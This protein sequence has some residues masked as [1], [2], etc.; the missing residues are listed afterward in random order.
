MPTH[1]SHR[2]AGY[3]ALIERLSLGVPTPWHRSLVAASNTQRVDVTAAGVTEIYPSRYWPGDELC[4]HLEFALKYDGTDL[5][6]LAQVLPAIGPDALV[7]WI[8]RAPQG[9]YARRAWHLFEMLTRQLL[10]IPDLTRGNYIDL[11]DADAYYVSNAP[12][13]VRRQR[14]NDNLL[15][16]ADFC[17]MVRRTA[18]IESFI[19]KDFAARSRNLMAAY[20]PALLR[21]ALSYLYTKET[22]SSFEIE[23]I[24]PDPTRTER[25][26]ALLRSAATEDLCAK[27]SL[28]A[29]QNQIVDARF[30]EGDYRTDQNY[31][32]ETV[33]YGR[34]RIHYVCP[35]PEH[36]SP[37][38]SGLVESHARMA[39]SGVHPVIHA[40]AI[41][42]GFVFVHPFTDGNGRLHRLLIHN[43]LTR[44]AFVPAGLVFPVS[45]AMLERPTEYD[46]SLEAFSRPIMG[47]ADY[48]LDEDGRMHVR[49]DLGP[50][51]RYPDMTVQVEMLFGFVEQT[52]ESVLVNEL[53]FL[54]NYDRTK[55]A[56]QAVVDLP[57]KDIDLFIRL[58]LQ[59]AG[60]MSETKRKSAFASLS[61][62][63][64]ERLERCVQLGYR[65]ADG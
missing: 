14:V 59:N 25:F 48:T 9:K 13:R 34:E 26:V 6:L 5:A 39:S 62:D 19:G 51:Y 33:H 65:K 60:R 55:S 8:G 16:G 21:R 41:G 57:D 46:A 22:K 44:R 43:I 11:I 49:N 37:L 50:L 23:R 15:G 2:P 7:A 29:A 64:V 54:A 12:V 18:A 27:P 31:I 38:M 20:P 35:R 36:V 63:E 58:Y 56:M 24:T 53:E 17:P 30:R 40:A 52:V 4:D 61:D 42:Y 47:L 28:I 1:Q 3:A 32:G 10:P 45:V